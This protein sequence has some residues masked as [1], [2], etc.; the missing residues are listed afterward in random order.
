MHGKKRHFSRDSLSLILPSTG[1]EF[2]CV[3]VPE[4]L[5]E[6][7]HTTQTRYPEKADEQMVTRSRG[8]QGWGWQPPWLLSLLEHLWALL[9]K[10]SL[11]NNSIQGCSLKFPTPAQGQV[12]TLTFLRS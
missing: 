6:Q 12:G 4:D 7:Y 1:K 9:R 11:D 10:A 5:L 8:T 3:P 2:L